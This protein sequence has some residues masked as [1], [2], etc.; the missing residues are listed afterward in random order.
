M[1]DTHADTATDRRE[2]VLEAVE[3]V[4]QEARKAVA[5]HAT[6]DGL[7]VFI[8]GSLAVYLTGSGTRG[9]TVRI[10][11][12]EGL[13]STGEAVGLYIPGSLTVA[14]ID[15]VVLGGTLIVALVDAAV[16]YRRF[17]VTQLEAY[18][19][20]LEVAF[21]TARDAASDAK[22]S[23]VAGHLYAEVLEGLERASTREFVRWRQMYAAFGVVLLLAVVGAGVVGLGLEVG[24]GGGD[25][26]PTI[27]TGGQDFVG[28]EAPVDRGSESREIVLGQTSDTADVTGEYDAGEFSIDTASLEAAQ[29]SFTD[30]TRPENAD[31]VRDYYEQLR[32]DTAEDP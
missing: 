26:T 8:V 30:E 18:N 2:A 22:D 21:R 24:D 1:S 28:E 4:R 14:G 23:P 10:G 9:G 15:V 12:P 13:A 25:T 20:E 6:V 5:L 7:L 16:R 3:E 11:L 29:A 17:D 19:P 32:G 31:L 27:D